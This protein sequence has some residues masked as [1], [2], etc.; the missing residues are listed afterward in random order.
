MASPR[1]LEDRLS[2]LEATKPR[3]TEATR[4]ERKILQ[5]M[6]LAD[7]RRLEGLL[8]R[9]EEGDPSAA[10]TAAEQEWLEKIMKRVRVPDAQ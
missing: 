1:E 6:S 9:I 10:L 4:H 5:A 2:R 8:T 7:L 3:E